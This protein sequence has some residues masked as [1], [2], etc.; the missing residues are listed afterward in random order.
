M[1]RLKYFLSDGYSRTEIEN[2]I[3]EW[4]VGR[5][6]ARDRGVLRLRFIEGH[7]IE[8]IAEK[9]RFI[10]RYYKEYYLPL[11]SYNKWE[12]KVYTSVIYL[13]AI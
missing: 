5:N 2:V 7:T 9:K 13:L 6:S 1:G 11:V 4:V 12:I 3:D 10:D 8:Y